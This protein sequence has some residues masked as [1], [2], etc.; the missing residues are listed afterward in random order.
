MNFAAGS[1]RLIGGC[2][3]VA[4][5]RLAAT[6]PGSHV[7][8]VST[9]RTPRRTVAFA[10]REPRSAVDPIPCDAKAFA[11]PEIVY[12]SAITIN[13]SLIVTFLL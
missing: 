10:G 3:F 11:P 7:D 12:S 2:A 6:A 8:I 1:R 5:T 9:P 4:T 13:V